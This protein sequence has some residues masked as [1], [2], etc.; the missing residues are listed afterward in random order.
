ML[1]S[2]TSNAYSVNDTDNNLP[3]GNILNKHDAVLLIDSLLIKITI[4]ITIKRF[5]KS[6][7]VN[8]I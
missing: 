4:I 2:N 1:K 3:L 6:D 7:Y 8:N 5:W